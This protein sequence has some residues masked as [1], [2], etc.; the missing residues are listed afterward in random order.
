MPKRVLLAAAGLLA[1]AATAVPGAAQA[2]SGQTCQVT[3]G[4]LEGDFTSAPGDTWEGAPVNG[5]PG[6]VDIQRFTHPLY[7]T[8]GIS[9]AAFDEERAWFQARTFDFTSHDVVTWG[10]GSPYGDVTITC[11]D[12]TTRSGGLVINFLATGNYLTNSFTAHFEIVGSSG[13]LAGTTGNGTMTGE[14]GVPGGNG[15][16][17][18]TIHL[19]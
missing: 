8:G 15:T 9:G 7:I 5:F 14:P 18:A 13:G 12:G 11:P 19:R 4:M 17:T 3:G 10:P 2:A 1:A 6:T 16:Y